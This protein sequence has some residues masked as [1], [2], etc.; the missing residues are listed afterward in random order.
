MNLLN[1]D[2]QRYRQHLNKVIVGFIASF[3]LLALV[4]GQL[5]I[6]IFAEPGGDNFWL[7]LSGVAIAFIIVASVINHFKHHPFMTEILYVWQLKQQINY[8]YRKLKPIEA[9]A[10][11]QS[12]IN[13]L[14]CL[15]FYYQACRQLYLLDDNTITLSS[16]TTAENKLKLF[17]DDH[18]LTIDSKDYQ[19][20]LLTAF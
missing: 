11:T 18:N 4:F 14:I 12:N 19:Q 7:N 16:L 9:Q 17:I 2:K 8:I 13:A 6:S 3:L 15:S 1:I 10:F 5:L 20:Q